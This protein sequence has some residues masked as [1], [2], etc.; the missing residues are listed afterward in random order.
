LSRLGRVLRVQPGEGRT[1]GLVLAMMFVT[2]AGQ[3]IGESGVSALFFDRVGTSALPLMYLLQGAT[4][5][6]AMLVLTG[7][8]G[9]G[10]RRR[11][12][13]GLLLALSAAVVLER[14]LLIGEQRWVYEVLWLTASLGT[15]LEAIVVWGTAGLV[16]DT[17]RAK[18]LFPLFGAGSILGAIVGGLLTG[19]LARA[20]GAQNLLFVWAAALAGSAALCAAALGTGRKR[21][22]KSVRARRRRVSRVHE[23]S[24]GL[25]SVRRSPLLMWMMTAAVLFSVLFFSLY[26]PFAEAAS[27]RFQDPD[28]LAGFLGLFWAA[29]T[30]VAFLVAILLTNRLLGWLGA[31]VLVLVLPVLY[32]GAFGVLLASSALTTLVVIRFVV[33]VWLQG[34]ASPSWET[35]INVV[36]ES[37][38]DQTRAFLNGGPTQVGTA[39]AGVIQLVGQDV[40]SARQLAVIGLACAGITI[41]AV[42]RIRRSYTGALVDALRS[43]R[44][45]V[46]EVGVLEG[47]PI[48]LDREGQAMD[49]ALN[50]ACDPDVRIRR[51]AV[52]MLAAATGSRARDALLDAARDE[53]ALVRT[54]AIRGL[55]DHGEMSVVA[56]ALADPD[57]GVRLAAIT[58]L[59]SRAEASQLDPLLA[60]DDP[61]VLAAGAVALLGTPSR[62]QALL[63]IERLARDDDPGVRVT[64][65]RRLA[66]ANE[67]DI[68]LAAPLTGDPAPSVRAAALVTL[69]TAGP[70]TVIRPAL[71]ALDSA[72]GSV[73]AVALDLLS[74][75]DL[76]EHTGTIRALVE[77]RAGLALRDHALAA[78]VPRDGDATALLRDALVDRARR[79]AMASLSALA[80]VSVDGAAMRQA[81]E[82]LHPNES[83]QLATA[84]EAMEAA[85]RDPLARSLVALWE[86]SPIAPTHP[87]DDRWLD[88][89]LG[90]G[91]PVIRSFAVL[92]RETK[93][94]GDQM[95]SERTSMS[96]MERVLELQRIPLF[97]GLSPAE[98]LQVAAIAEERAYADGEVIAEEGEIGEELH[99]ILAGTVQVVRQEDGS[100]VPVAQRVPG[101]VVGEM[102]IISRAPRV[103]S[104]VVEGDVRTITIGRREFESM[105]A[106]RP[107]VALAVMRVLAERLGAVTADRARRTG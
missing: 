100:A 89:A 44:P 58:E 62:R 54:K 20:I 96:P 86:S 64:V 47:T 55:A 36:P 51:L 9:H 42:S 50:A 82:N 30:G 79:N 93:E 8:L 52:E 60:D 70:E 15:L 3:T 87:K 104:L 56:G 12:Y 24:Q 35:L 37:R 19:P 10:D 17:R 97:A 33:N 74:D 43:G 66:L 40:L 81:L 102:S 22:V 57:V 107:D 105:I 95:A 53:D 45:S 6:V 7:S 69:G 46:F 28:A 39:I 16:T 11:T 76:G 90:D 41:F 83:G 103:A 61:A 77:T 1:V 31:A 21:T 49:I 14:G 29:V 80:L 23:L 78:S 26:L 101:D 99:I 18:R 65:V 27:L 75:L 32:A 59:G 94:R 38:R 68:Q 84:L 48:V 91:D 71:E 106:E 72:D 63:V 25:A 13:G 88:E 85:A 73:R 4:G 34:V 92:V 67:A 98:L 5:L 2:V